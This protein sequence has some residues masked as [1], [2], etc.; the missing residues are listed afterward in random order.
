MQGDGGDNLSA[1]TTYIHLFGEC[2]ML[3]LS[4]SA[5][6]Q[7]VFPL[8]NVIL[9]ILSSI[10]MVSITKGAVKAIRGEEDDLG[11]YQSTNEVHHK[12]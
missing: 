6:A 12:D 4:T 8:T 1:A 11:P 7:V 3:L 10:W 5:V 2:S 9:L